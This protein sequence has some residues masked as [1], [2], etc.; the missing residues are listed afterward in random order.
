ML[1]PVDVHYL[2]GLLTLTASEEDVDVELGSMVLDRSTGTERDVAV[3][4]TQRTQAGGVAAYGG[5][6]VKKH[7]R[8]LSTEHVE[9]LCMKLKDMPGLTYRAVVSASGYSKPS[10]RKAAA[11]GVDLLELV[12]PTEIDLAGFSV[13][14]GQD[15]FWE[16]LALGWVEHRVTFLPRVTLSVAEREGLSRGLLLAADGEPY[17]APSLAHVATNLLNNALEQ[18]RHSE[19]VASRAAGVQHAI[20][21]LVRVEHPSHVELGERTLETSEAGI[22]GVVA[23]A[24]RSV[25]V[26]LHGLKRVIDAHPHVGCVVAEVGPGH[27]IGL[28][29]KQS[30]ASPLITIPLF[31][32]DQEEDLPSGCLEANPVRSGGR[33]LATP[34]HRG[35]PGRGLITHHGTLPGREAMKGEFK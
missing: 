19:E 13:R 25:K 28:V 27:I 30:G 32:Q 20:Q 21:V 18:L 3:T 17:P 26:E 31:R 6:E 16:E 22:R 35:E 11:H 4:V 2:V 5:I 14:L 34:R 33:L 10:K 12:P 24:R 7:G 29:L 15:F 23:W 9:Q 1:T 8:K